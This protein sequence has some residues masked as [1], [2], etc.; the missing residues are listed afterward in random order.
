MDIP[1]R[2]IGIG[3]IILPL[4]VCFT[5]Y[6]LSR[7]EPKIIRINCSVAEFNPEIPYEIRKA[8]KELRRAKYT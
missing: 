2:S 3:I 7:E 5:F 6:R 4:L 1:S 8:C